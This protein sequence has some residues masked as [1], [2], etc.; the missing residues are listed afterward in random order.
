MDSLS[1]SVRQHRFDGDRNK[2]P[3]AE[4]DQIGISINKTRTGEWRGSCLLIRLPE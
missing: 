3:A 1:L 2:P 4:R